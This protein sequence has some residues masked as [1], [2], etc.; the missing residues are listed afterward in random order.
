MK[1]GDLVR[2]K[3]GYYEPPANPLGVII[4]EKQPE[5]LGMNITFRVYEVLFASGTYKMHEYEMELI[6]DDG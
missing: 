2:C 3:L 1:V 4:N 5:P 6:N